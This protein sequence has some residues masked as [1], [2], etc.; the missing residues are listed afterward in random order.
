MWDRLIWCIMLG[1]T[2]PHRGEDATEAVSY[3]DF[4]D[5]ITRLQESIGKLS[6]DMSGLERATRRLERSTRDLSKTQR[7]ISDQMARTADE[8]RSANRS[9][10]RIDEL[11]AAA[12]ADD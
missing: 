11:P 6:D 10:A 2:T 1:M 4:G 5:A 8:I 7:E 3:T 9:T 12:V